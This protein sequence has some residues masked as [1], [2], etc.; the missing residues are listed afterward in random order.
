[1]NYSSSRVSQPEA[2]APFKAPRSDS[3]AETRDCHGRVGVTVCLG[4]SA[5]AA[6]RRASSGGRGPP[7][8]TVSSADSAGP[9][10]SE[11]LAVTATPGQGQVSN[12]V[13]AFSGCRLSATDRVRAR[14]LSH[15]GSGRPPAL[16]LPSRRVPPGAAAAA[17]AQRNPS[18]SPSAPPRP[19]HWQTT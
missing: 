13:A 17:A 18:Q 11:K 2:R 10:Q 6:R 15:S 14:T 12:R 19:G 4:V 3:P 9:S 8:V 5:L 1:M 16:R 7:R